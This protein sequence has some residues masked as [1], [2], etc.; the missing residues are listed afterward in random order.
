MSELDDIMAGTGADQLSDQLG[1]SV[2]LTDEAAAD[3]TVTAM[4]VAPV[5][6]KPDDDDRDGEMSRAVTLRAADVAPIDRFSEI[7]IA[8]DTWAIEH[9]PVSASAALITIRA[10]A[11]EVVNRGSGDRRP[12]RQ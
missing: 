11:A 9:P 10:L 7:V 5:E 3:L 6:T 1:E 12:W 2:T 8:G 4:A